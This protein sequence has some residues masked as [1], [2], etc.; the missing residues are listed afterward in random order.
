MEEYAAKGKRKLDF[1]FFFQPLL[2]VPSAWGAS[3]GMAD[4]PRHSNALI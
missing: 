1:F 4:L 3:C 2:P